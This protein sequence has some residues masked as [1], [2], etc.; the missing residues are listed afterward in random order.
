MSKVY[1]YEV[2]LRLTMAQP[3]ESDILMTDS[4]PRMIDAS[5]RA[6]MEIKEVARLD[7]GNGP[8]TNGRQ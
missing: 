7:H 3:I 4:I 6:V 8:W 1:E 5:T 2:V